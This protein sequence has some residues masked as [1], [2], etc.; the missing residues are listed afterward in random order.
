MGVPRFAAAA[1]TAPATQQTGSRRTLI[2]HT[3]LVASRY[4]LPSLTQ[5]FQLNKAPSR[6]ERTGGEATW[7]AFRKSPEHD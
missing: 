1:A 5:A 3:A 4:P 2:L 6:L 7:S